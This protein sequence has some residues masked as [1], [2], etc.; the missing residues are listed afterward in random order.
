MALG[1]G[2]KPGND[3]EPRGAGIR[4][5]RV[6]A[7]AVP[8]IVAIFPPSL[9]FDWS[10]GPL[11][12]WVLATAA[13]GLLSFHLVNIFRTRVKLGHWMKSLAW[14]LCSEILIGCVL[15][16]AA[17][18]GA[19]V[20]PSSTWT[21]AAL[22]VVFGFCQVL[23][24]PIEQDIREEVEKANK[25][26]GTERFRQRR[27]LL[28]FG[29]RKSIQV[30]SEKEHAPGLWKGLIAL[31]K[32]PWQEGLSR[33]RSLILYTLL[34]CAA[35]S[36]AAGADVA[37]HDW[38]ANHKDHASTQEG[39][40]GGSGSTSAGTAEVGGGEEGAGGDGA[41]L[42]EEEEHCLVQP[43]HGAP[44]WARAYLY[45][46]YYGG[47]ELEATEPPGTKVGGCTGKVF[48][49]PALKGSF[50]FTIGRNAAGEVRSVAVDSVRFGPAIFLAPA[51]QQV[52]ALIH[53]GVMPLGGYPRE[54]AGAGDMVPVTTPR[55][56]LILVRA[57]KVLPGKPTYATPYIELP[58][59]VATL[60]VEAMRVE[61]GWLWPREPRTLSDG[62]RVY[63][64]SRRVGG[65]TVGPS[66]SFDPQ[67]GIAVSSAGSLELP[68]PQLSKDELT[69][70]ALLAR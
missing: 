62:S 3:P 58:V 23:Y 70:F 28:F 19:L 32:D 26:H 1:G 18:V 50:V 8:L 52:L 59:T 65:G 48:V 10:A 42:P 51:A 37:M 25:K 7:M 61:G 45:A 9:I 27:L 41:D 29:S 20:L 69:E 43:G 40:A 68:Q 49:P 46:L 4:C 44:A 5:L 24:E 67:S 11:A 55:G 66:V 38:I 33:T 14:L 13:A 30:M 2:L 63:S 36:T 17:L 39:S 21:F 34:F 53:E 12:K 57:A 16:A 56:T 54:D 6:I 15:P 22:T 35:F 47:L 60:W 64:F 31:G